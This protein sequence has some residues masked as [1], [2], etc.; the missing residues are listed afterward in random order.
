MELGFEGGIRVYEES[1]DGFDTNNWF[2]IYI[3]NVSTGAK[4]YADDDTE[5]YNLVG[6]GKRIITEGNW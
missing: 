6:S 4:V 2:G 3:F 5:V 1:F